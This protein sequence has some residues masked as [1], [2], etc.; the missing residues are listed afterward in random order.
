LLGAKCV[1]VCTAVMEFGY[2]IIES[3][4][5]Q[6]DKYL[7]EHNTSIDKLVGKSLEY[8]KLPEELDRSTKCVYEIDSKECLKCGRCF[9][10]CSDGGHCAIENVAGQYQINKS[11]CKGCGLCKLVCP[12][13][14]I[15]FISRIA[16]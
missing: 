14:C 12:K 15:K 8:V 5:K 11:L 9:K 10:S 16:K 1:Q 13:K 4:L 6:L 3:N 2:D 7:Q